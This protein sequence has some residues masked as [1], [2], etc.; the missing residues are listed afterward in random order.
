MTSAHTKESLQFAKFFDHTLLKP[1]ATAAQ[2]EALCLEA[3]ENRFC[4]VCVN[5]G[6]IPLAH[7]LLQGTDVLPITVV[8]FPLGATLTRSKAFEAEEAIKAGA[9]E[10]DMVLNVGWLKSGR[11]NDCEHDVREVVKASGRVPVK[12]ILETSLLSSEEIGVASR[13]SEA[14]GAAFVKTSTGF[15]SRGASRDDILTMKANVSSKVLIKA[16]GGLRTLEAVETMIAAGANR[17]G[18]SSSVQILKDW[19]QKNGLVL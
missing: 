7:T 16:S 19:A 10:I 3:R 9:R 6:W 8:G 12:V 2:I 5:A 14:G 15:G 17:V 1:E 4:T 11:A 13:L 18:S